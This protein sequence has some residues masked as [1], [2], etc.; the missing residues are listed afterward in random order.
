VKGEDKDASAVLPVTGEEAYFV[1]YFCP[2]Q[3]LCG[4]SICLTL[5]DFKY[6]GTPLYLTDDSYNRSCFRFCVVL[7]VLLG[8]GGSL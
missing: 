4:K 1:K 6:C 3:E 2:D 5:D 8:R 7:V